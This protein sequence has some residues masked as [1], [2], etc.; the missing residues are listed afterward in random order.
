MTSTPQ[1]PGR[2]RRV[3]LSREERLAQIIEAS[4]RLV[5]RQGFWGLSLQEVAT[6]VGITQAGLL[7]YVHTKEGLLQLLI[8]QGY[9]RRFDPEDF[10]ATGDAAATHPDGASFP[11]YCRYL[12]ANNARDP[13]L[14]RLYMVLGAESMSP[15]HPAHAYFD[16]RPD[17]VWQLYSATRWRIPPEIGG[18][19]A[20]RELVEL[21]IA[22]MD[23]LQLRMFR[24]PAI[25]LPTEWSKAERVLFPSPVW[26]DYR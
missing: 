16:A 5:S 9:D 18:W 22:T 15:E 21:T 4:T 14:I 11:A 12:V 2:P 25:D 3:R 13:Q 19:P 1:T 24:S 20:M 26:D 17:A 7:H 23:G 10:I 8:E 6:E